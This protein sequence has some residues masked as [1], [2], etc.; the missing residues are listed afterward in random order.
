MKQALFAAKP[1]PQTRNTFGKNY[2][3]VISAYL[4]L[5]SLTVADIF[6][7]GGHIQEDSDR[8]KSFKLLLDNEAMKALAKQGRIAA[9]ISFQVRT[10]GCFAVARL[11]KNKASMEAQTGAENVSN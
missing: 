7:D 5:R 1:I 2:P 9:I 4:S 3:D 8:G 6:T 10:T 11:F